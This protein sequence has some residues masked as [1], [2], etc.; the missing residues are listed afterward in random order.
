[1]S[2]LTSKRTKSDRANKPSGVYIPPAKRVKQEKFEE[3][4]EE[5][6]K[7]NWNHLRKRITGLINRVNKS[8][9]RLIIRELFG[10]NL[11]RGKGIFASAIIKAQE[12]SPIFTDVYAAL[13]TAINSR[14]ASIGLLVVDR[15]ILQYRTAFAN[16]NKPKCLATARFIAHLTNQE[17]VHEILALQILIH[18]LEKPTPFSIEIAIAF[19]KEAGAKL[20]EL[21]P[22][23]LFAVFEQLRRLTSDLNDKLDSRTLD[24]IDVVHMIRKSKFEDFPSVKPGLDLIEEKDKITHQREITEPTQTDYYL[25][26]NHFKL[27]PNYIENEAKYELLKK[28]V[29]GEE[30]ETSSEEDDDGE[31]VNGSSSDDDEEGEDKEKEEM[32][33][34]D[35]TGAKLTDFR[36][37][38]YLTIRSSLS[39]E[40]CAH[41]LLKMNI[42]KNLN[43][44]L[45]YMMLD[46]CAQQRTYNQFSGLLA[47]LFCK[48]NKKEYAQNFENIFMSVYETIHRQESNKIRNTAKFFA[49]L[50]ATDS[51]DWTILKVIKLGEQTTTSRGRV[52]VKFLFEELT[53]TL[54]LKRLDERIK[55]PKNSEAFEGLFPKDDPRNTKF[56]INFFTSINLGGLTDDLRETLE[57][58]PMLLKNEKVPKCEKSD[59]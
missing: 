41:K 52:F 56:A 14:I 48:L 23:G 30:E 39:H 17:V 36:R 50:L 6:Q 5:N 38:V 8:N 26:L 22:S 49:H 25:E 40:E 20:E 34:I 24:M 15:L 7:L 1:M 4:S 45:C 10:L 54:T 28:V 2:S 42:P 11:I 9:I 43:D 33:I 47:E 19:L 44:E 21:A 27:D 55:D 3:S 31:S 13:L 12:T 58:G 29:L 32:K 46:F 37:N 53:E 18:L 35:Q 16:D 51:I 57:N 59:D